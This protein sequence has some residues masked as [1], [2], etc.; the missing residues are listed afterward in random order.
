VEV[1]RM[2]RGCELWRGEFPAVTN[3]ESKHE[4]CKTQRLRWYQRVIL[5]MSVISKAQKLSMPVFVVVTVKVI[6]NAWKW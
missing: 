2:W 6:S 1:L 3:M 5:I 4:T